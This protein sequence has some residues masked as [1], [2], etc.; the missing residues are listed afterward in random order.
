M[1]AFR[2]LLAAHGQAT[3]NRSA[4]ELGRQGAWVLALVVGRRAVRD[5]REDEVIQWSDL[6]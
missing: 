6:A 5:L 2:A 4:R 1:S 3:W